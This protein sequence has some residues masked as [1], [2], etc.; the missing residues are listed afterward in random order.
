MNKQLE[1]LLQ[2]LGERVGLPDLAWDEGGEC[3]LLFDDNVGINLSV[4]EDNQALVLYSIVGQLAPSV[5]T[6]AYEQLMSANFFWKDTL[7]ATLGADTTTGTI[8]MAQSIPLSIIDLDVLENML[9]HFIGL[10]ENWMKRL[11]KLADGLETPPSS[12]ENNSTPHSI[13]YG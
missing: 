1:T 9:E 11:A 3:T 12:I 4:E 2:Q 6:Q 8:V 5:R 7:G 10:T 13:I